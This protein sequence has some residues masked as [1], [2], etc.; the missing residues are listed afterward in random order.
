MGMEE[1]SVEHNAQGRIEKDWKLSTTIAQREGQ[2][3]EHQ[4]SKARRTEEVE[5]QN[6]NTL[7]THIAHAAVTRVQLHT[8]S[9]Q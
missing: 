9:L 5:H 1:R 6:N 4:D 8:H 2:D 7:C 3:V